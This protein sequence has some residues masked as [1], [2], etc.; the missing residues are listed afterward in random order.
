M[1]LI[2][3]IQVGSFCWLVEPIVNRSEHRLQL[4]SLR[5]LPSDVVLVVERVDQV[6]LHPR[7]LKHLTDVLLQIVVDFRLCRLQLI[8]ILEIESVV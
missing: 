5:V 7:K 8:A 2:E 3:L 6:E 1:Q 4:L